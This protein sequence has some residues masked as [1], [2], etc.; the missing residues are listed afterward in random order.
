MEGVRQHVM[1]DER[2]SPNGSVSVGEMK[3]CVRVELL[4]SEGGEV[5]QRSLAGFLLEANDV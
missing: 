4:I 5:L 2:R 3:F 1:E